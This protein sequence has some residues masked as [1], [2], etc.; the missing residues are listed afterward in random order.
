MFLGDYLH[1]SDI[2]LDLQARDAN[3][4]LLE[5]AHPLALTLGLDEGEIARLLQNRER[6][7]PTAIGGSVAA[8]H[9]CHPRAARV[10]VCFARSRA[11]LPMGARDGLPGHLLLAFVR[12]THSVREHLGLLGC[13][14]MIVQDTALVRGLLEAH[15]PATIASLLAD[16][17]VSGDFDGLAS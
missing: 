9:A 7:G 1:P 2:L 10:A 12:P 4:A 13:A 6:M 15:N 14:S 11:G 5:M 16:L 17:R 8:P 3:A